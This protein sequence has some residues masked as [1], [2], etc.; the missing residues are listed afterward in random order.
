[1]LATVNRKGYV[2][3]GHAMRYYNSSGAGF[4]IRDDEW[5]DEEIKN[6][7]VATWNAEFQYWEVIE[8]DD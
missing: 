1:M 5:N 7:E 8:N 2:M 3:D 4:E 6:W